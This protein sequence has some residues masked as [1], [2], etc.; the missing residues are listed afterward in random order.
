MV[1]ITFISDD[2]LT[3]IEDDRVTEVDAYS[4]SLAELNQFIGLREEGWTLDDVIANQTEDA[5][6]ILNDISL[7]LADNEISA[8]KKKTLLINKLPIE[9]FDGVDGPVGTILISTSCNKIRQ[10]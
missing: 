9:G 2:G 6:F 3:V 1:D 4:V 8:V 7:A 10:L 5:E